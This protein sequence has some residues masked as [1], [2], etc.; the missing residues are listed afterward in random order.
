MLRSNPTTSRKAGSSLLR[1]MASRH[2]PI[3]S[4][5]T[6]LSRA[7][8]PRIPEVLS[9]HLRSPASRTKADCGTAEIL[10]SHLAR[11]AL[12]AM[13]RLLPAVDQVSTGL[14]TAV[15][16][17]SITALLQERSHAAAASAAAIEEGASVEAAVAEASAPA[18]AAALAAV[19]AAVVLAAAALVALAVVPVAAASVL[20]VA[21]VLAVV[22]VEAAIPAVVPSGNGQQNQPGTAGTGPTPT[23]G[24]GL[25]R[26]GTFGG[27]ATAPKVTSGA[28]AGASRSGTAGTGRTSS[29]ESGSIKRGTTAVSA[30]KA[31]GSHNDGRPAGSPSSPA[32]PLSARSTRYSAADRG[33]RQ[34]SAGAGTGAASSVSAKRPSGTSSGQSTHAQQTETRSTR[35]EK[36]HSE[37]TT[38]E[39]TIR[40][41][42]DRPGTAGKAAS[43]PVRQSAQ[44]PQAGRLVPPTAGVSPPKRQ[45][46]STARQETRQ[47]SVPDNTAQ[48]GMSSTPAAPAASGGG[49]RAHPGTAGTAPEHFRA[50]QE[51]QAAG[52]NTERAQKKPGISGSRTG[53]GLTPP[54]KK[55]VAGSKRPDRS[56][57]RG[58]TS[59]GG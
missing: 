27:T 59:H 13:Y 32:A 8:L 41:S 15:I 35:R 24:D 20:T 57:H 48:T 51:S 52:K 7:V 10:P 47:T 29:A 18:A 26:R 21:A 34:R 36:L 14:K 30:D 46:S 23:S 22:P 37:R 16:R 49:T 5:Q 2:Q 43:G 42:E 17:P 1:R 45:G 50:S 33:K 11:G 28:G 56:R 12:P 4:S 38:V 39:N 44:T 9:T 40:R 19:P 6:L 58:G 53:P 25:S 31:G 55:S 3:R 54:A